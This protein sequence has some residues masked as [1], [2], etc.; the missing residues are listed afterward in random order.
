MRAFNVL[1]LLWLANYVANVDGSESM[2][3]E[4]KGKNDGR[5]LQWYSHPHPYHH[6][7]YEVPLTARPTPHPTH[8]PT[9]YPSPRPTP[10]PTARPSA[11]PTPYPSPRPTPHPTPKPTLRPTYHPTPAP[12]PKPTR[13][14]T[15]N[16]TPEPTPRPTIHPTPHPTK[17]PTCPPT[18]TP[19]ER[20]TPAPTAFPTPS[21][22][23]RP[24]PEP[25]RRRPTRRPVSQEPS[26]E[27][28]FSLEPSEEPSTSNEPSENPSFSFV[29]DGTIAEC[30]CDLP[31]TEE[32]CTLIRDTG[33]FS[34]LDSVNQEFTV[35]AP[36]DLAFETFFDLFPPDF[37]DNN[38]NRD[39]EEIESPL[40]TIDQSSRKLEHEDTY[41]RWIPYVLAAHVVESRALK[42]DDLS[43]EGEGNVI[44]M[45]RSTTQTLCD[46]NEPIGQRGTCN[47]FAAEP[48]FIRTDIKADNGI[49]HYIDKVII[50]NPI[51][52]GCA[53][54][55]IDPNNPTIPSIPG[56]IV[57]VPG[58]EN[59]RDIIC[60]ERGDDLSK[61]CSLLRKTAVAFTSMS[62]NTGPF[63][64]FQDENSF[65]TVFA[66]T[67]TA[68]DA[69]LDDA[70]IDQRL[71]DAI[72]NVLEGPT[73]DEDDFNIVVN[74]LN[75]HFLPEG[76]TISQLCEE[77]T[78]LST[79]LENA[80]VGVVC[81]STS[82][83]TDVTIKSDKNDDS[84][85]GPRIDPGD[86]VAT[87]GVL[88]TI[89]GILISDEI[90]P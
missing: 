48:S 64:R 24:T 42:E 33:F 66:P 40:M 3:V 46:N 36:D 5:K 77:D 54:I 78:V 84:G 51:I 12:I 89:D 74:F 79:G 2:N 47:F 70:S 45:V 80:N 10:H 16:P 61:F 4:E 71:R 11:M 38:N 41:D 62:D 22:S 1:R 31:Q 63:F 25:T 81:A 8:K 29:C 26:E 9:P 43:C 56:P 7:S 59:I 6:Y 50:P 82:T 28:T 83:S 65:S 72:K 17:M 21:P 88:H 35:F 27:P 69:K 55:G 23:P 14:P 34:Q 53:A 32:L 52:G 30:I 44:Q 60:D 37:F 68:L 75:L 58:D 20:P 39:L 73:N 13:L 49:I 57:P 87:N 15:P 18:E 85:A 19:S 86:D 76:Y 67:D 90:F